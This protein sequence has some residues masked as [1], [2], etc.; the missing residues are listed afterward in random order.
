QITNRVYSYDANGNMTNIDGLVCTWDFKDRLV[1]VEDPTMR[2]E[3]TYDATGRRIS[4][5]VWP[6]AGT[7]SLSTLNSQLSTTL[8]IGNHFEVRDHDAPT[9][10]VF[11]GATRVASITGSLSTNTRIQR[12]RI[13]PGWNL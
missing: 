12:L 4:K 13:H 7:N 1:A 9:K 5:R 2:A 6:K 11:N 8:Y 10:Y 3:Y